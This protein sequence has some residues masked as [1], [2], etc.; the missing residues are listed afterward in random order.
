MDFS[1]QNCLPCTFRSHAYFLIGDSAHTFKDIEMNV[2]E[3]LTKTAE[4]YFKNVEE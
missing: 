3:F 4:G 2:V 1:S